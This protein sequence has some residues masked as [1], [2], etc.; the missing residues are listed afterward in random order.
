[1]FTKAPEDN[2]KHFGNVVRMYVDS[3][4]DMRYQ[5]GS[6][7]QFA[8]E[9]RPKLESQLSSIDEKM[10]ALMID[11]PDSE[12]LMTSWAND[13]RSCRTRLD[14][15]DRNVPFAGKR[16]WNWDLVIASLSYILAFTELSKATLRH[17]GISPE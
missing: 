12:T 1:M 10:I 9:T 6:D 7:I 16:Q 8:T 14:E 5:P 17:N 2:P 11:E 15:I 13:M 4:D 3:L